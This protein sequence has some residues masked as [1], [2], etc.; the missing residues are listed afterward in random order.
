M[1]LYAEQWQHAW[2]WCLEGNIAFICFIS[3]ILNI[4]SVCDWFERLGAVGGSNF[5]GILLNGHCELIFYLYG[6]LILSKFTL[7]QLWTK[8]KFQFKFLHIFTFHSTCM[9]VLGCSFV[10][11][12]L[13]TNPV[14]P[15]TFTKDKTIQVKCDTWNWFSK[16][17]FMLFLNKFLTHLDLNCSYWYVL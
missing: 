2:F 13:N 10:C 15:S 14:E 17:K 3:K 4:C 9:L 1:S 11:F 12:F 5:V 7:N 16:I 8:H 6:I